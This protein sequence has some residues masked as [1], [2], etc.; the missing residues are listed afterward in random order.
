M[1]ARH[2]DEMVKVTLFWVYGFNILTS[3]VRGIELTLH[4]T[5][6]LTLLS[7]I[8][9]KNRLKSALTEKSLHV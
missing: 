9:Y 5:H 8:S 2:P 4:H 7:Y 3:S 6:P 1:Y